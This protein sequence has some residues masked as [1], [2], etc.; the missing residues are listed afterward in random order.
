M[1]VE[2][3]YMEGGFLTYQFEN[4]FKYEVST[5]GKDRIIDDLPWKE[6][7]FR[8]LSTK[9]WFTEEIKKKTLD[10]FKEL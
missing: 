7:W 4:S 10:I 5:D 8:H 3:V 1:K 6:W 9:L 2:N